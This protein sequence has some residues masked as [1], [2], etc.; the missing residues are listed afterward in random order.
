MF[1]VVFIAIPC[2]GIEPSVAVIERLPVGNGKSITLNVEEDLNVKKEHVVSVETPDPA[3]PNAKI[4]KAVTVKV[5]GLKVTTGD[6]AGPSHDLGSGGSIPAGAPVAIFFR[7]LT[8]QRLR[9]SLQFPPA[10]TNAGLTE[11]EKAKYCTPTC[12]LDLEHYKT[13]C[14]P[15]ENSDDPSRCRP[16]PEVATCGAADCEAIRK[17]CTKPGCT[18]DLYKALE[19]CACS[20]TKTVEP[21]TF[22]FRRNGVLNVSRYVPRAFGAYSLQIPEGVFDTL[23]SEERSTIAADAATNVSVEKAKIQLERVR[24][25]QEEPD[26]PRVLFDAALFGGK[27]GVPFKGDRYTFLIEQESIPPAPGE[28]LEKE[29]AEEQVRAAAP[30]TIVVSD[31]ANLTPTEDDGQPMRVVVV[32]LDDTGVANWRYLNP[33]NPACINCLPGG[34][35]LPPDQTPAGVVFRN[36]TQDRTFLISITLP[37]TARTGVIDEAAFQCTAG[38]PCK[39][40]RS[41]APQNTTLFDASIISLFPKSL[42]KFEV[43]L[44][45]ETAT[46]GN[47]A[48][49]LSLSNPFDEDR[50]SVLTERAS[51]TGF[52]TK[53]SLSGRVDPDFRVVPTADMV[54]AALEAELA[55]PDTTRTDEER[56]TA[57]L[58]S[59]LCTNPPTLADYKSEN[60]P[61]VCAD[62]PYIDGNTQA[63]RGSGSIN[64]TANLSDRAD[65]SAT[66]SFRDG[67]YGAEIDKTTVSEYNVTI[68]GVNGLSLKFGKA[69][70]LTPSSGIAISESGEGFLYSWRWLGLGHVIRRESTAGVPLQT[71]QDRKDW[72]L[73]ARSLS[74]FQSWRDDVSRHDVVKAAQPNANR[75]DPGMITMKRHLSIFRSGDLYVVRGEDKLA[76]S[77]YTTY[78]GEAFFSRPGSSPAPTK[79]GIVLRNIVSGSVAFYQSR[80]EVDVEANCDPTA[81]P[82][83]A[84]APRLCNGSGHV[85]LLTVTWTPSMLIA[86]G[87]N[88]ATSPH[89]VSLAIGQG[90]GNKPGTNRDEGYIGEPAFS[91]DKLFLKTFIP[92]MNSKG[93]QYVP[94]GLS[95]KRYTALTYTNSRTSI[96]D[97]VASLLDVENDVN[98]R[99]TVVGLREYKLR[100]SENGARGAAREVNVTFNIEVPK[101][102]TFSFDVNFLDPS[103][104]F[105]NRIK[106]RAWSFGANV[107]LSL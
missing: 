32:P 94:I 82:Y 80:K 27:D 61:S 20:V 50:K 42:I 41:V 11:K 77:T 45:G 30:V 74:L 88:A 99:S 76:N 107:T 96:F 48:A 86:N 85:W 5:H 22:T 9:I 92:K 79:E 40:T 4:T 24:I 8:R 69:D 73:Q 66:L 17:G 25:G 44:Y 57:F 46:L 31:S 16:V 33:R 68:Y 98:S 105:E 78:G 1:I 38:Q 101:G 65:G 12:K 7:N 19:A 49:Y 90:T 54:K 15:D 35:P 14:K 39:I 95:N 102:V 55:K 3:N 10:Q 84:V 72:F 47:A 59:Q 26:H 53:L 13:L 67:N 91:P 62:L 51:S 83:S 63:Y 29:P 93:V 34:Q 52:K 43:S 28:V 100:Y 58:D 21:S 36:R 23:S 37:A 106:E 104:A 71:N 18:V 89:T 64:L 97:F 103:E 56:T 87:T 81:T 75:R 60:E 2:A 70:F 6:P